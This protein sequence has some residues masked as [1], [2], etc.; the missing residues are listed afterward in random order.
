MTPAASRDS[1]GVPWGEVAPATGG[2]RPRGRRGGG[3]DV[4]GGGA[5]AVSNPMVG[6][7]PTFN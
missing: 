3:G 6:L 4:S 2:G 1:R 5:V 7:L